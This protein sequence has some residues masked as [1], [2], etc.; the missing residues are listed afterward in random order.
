M[1]KSGQNNLKRSRYYNDPSEETDLNR[2]KRQLSWSKRIISLFDDL[3]NLQNI[4]KV[5]FSKYWTSMEELKMYVNMFAKYL[6][7]TY[8]IKIPIYKMEDTS[9]LFLEF[10]GKYQKLGEGA[11]GFVVRENSGTVMKIYKTRDSL[12]ISILWEMLNLV[13]LRKVEECVGLKSVVIGKDFVG[14]KLESF[15]TN[16]RI[17]RKMN[18]DFFSHRTKRGLENLLTLYEQLKKILRG[19][20]ELGY[21]HR[22]LKPQNILIERKDDSFKI[23]LCDLGTVS[24]IGFTQSL[25]STTFQFCPNEG[26]DKE[27]KLETSLDMWS[28]G[29]TLIFMMNGQLFPFSDDSNRIQEWEQNREDIENDHDE[30]DQYEL[31]RDLDIWYCKNDIDACQLYNS[32]SE[33]RGTCVPFFLGQHKEQ[34]PIMD[35]LK[36]LL[37]IDPLRRKFF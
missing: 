5:R 24:K 14:L 32:K 8:A 36:S 15:G 34:K 35:R 31:L 33:Y 2:K 16:L 4:D 9:L 30:E 23:R 21:L 25:L 3:C 19:L 37:H 26:F 28:L 13:R 22:D 29:A 12:E 20:H 11:E 1:V 17:Y 10:D 6:E 7:N 27:I 18:P